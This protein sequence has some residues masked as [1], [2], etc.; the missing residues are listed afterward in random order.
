MA[1]SLS[2]RAYY[3]CPYC[4]CVHRA[5]PVRG[6]TKVGNIVFVVLWLIF[7]FPVVAGGIVLLLLGMV[8]ADAPDPEASPLLVPPW[9][10]ILGLLV[11]AFA[12]VGTWL[13]LRLCSQ[14]QLMCPGCRG[15]FS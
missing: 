12:S 7:L 6:R 14:K 4:R 3:R 15:R 13:L 10:T 8:H 11:L 2:R 9:A 1:S 5:I